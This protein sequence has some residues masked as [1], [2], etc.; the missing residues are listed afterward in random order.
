MGCHFYIY[1]DLSSFAPNG[2]NSSIIIMIIVMMIVTII[3]AISV[4][5]L[6]IVIIIIIIIII[7]DSSSLAPYGG[8]ATIYTHDHFTI[9]SIHCM[10]NYSV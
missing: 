5:L 7:M 3:T 10:F 9:P 1:L 2:G 4:I 6:I 8:R